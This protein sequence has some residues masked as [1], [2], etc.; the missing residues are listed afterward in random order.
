MHD[1]VDLPP[2]AET[3]PDGLGEQIAE[4][5]TLSM[6]VPQDSGHLIATRVSLNRGHDRGD[7]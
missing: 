3:L 7:L 6:T 5:D 4:L 2:T 1:G